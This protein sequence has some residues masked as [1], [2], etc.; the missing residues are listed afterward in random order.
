V[1]D[2]KDIYSRIVWIKEIVGMGP[3]RTSMVLMHKNIL[4]DGE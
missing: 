4:R 2:K 3:E 1:I